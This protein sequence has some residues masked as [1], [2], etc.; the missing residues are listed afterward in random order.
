MLRHPVY[1]GL[2]DDVEPRGRE[3]GGREADGGA[4][5][6][7]IAEAERRE[8]RPRN[9]RPQAGSPINLSADRGER[10]RGSS[11]TLPGGG[12]LKVGNL[13][14]VFWPANGRTKGDL[15]RYYAAVAPFILPV[16]DDRPL[17]MKRLPNGVRGKAFYQQRAPDEVPAGRARGGAARTTPACRRG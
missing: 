14:K 11:I 5:T 7:D 17:V 4:G 12:R 2:R 3:G 10:R 8:P 9:R 16:L 15:L 13:D 6:R 1:L